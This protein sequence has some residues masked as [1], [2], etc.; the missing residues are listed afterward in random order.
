MSQAPGKEQAGRS[1]KSL[2][3]VG[4]VGE[5]LTRDAS[6]LGYDWADSVP[7]WITNLAVAPTG[8]ISI[9]EFDDDSF[10]GWTTVTVT[11]GQT[12][13][14]GSGLL[15]VEPTTLINAP[16][17]NCILQSHSIAIG[18]AVVV[19]IPAH[20]GPEVNFLFGPL[21]TDG[22]T[23]G[24]LMAWHAFQP[25][26]SGDAHFSYETG[27]AATL[28]ASS[29]STAIGRVILGAVTYLR[30]EYDAANTFKNWTSA[31]NLTWEE[32]HSWTTTIT[33]THVGFGWTTNGVSPT[34]MA[35]ALEY[36]RVVTV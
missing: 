11:G 2:D 18:D 27:S 34:N 7:Q 3:N 30:I 8:D 26:G 4:S 13:T 5:V 6:D 31:D 28:T 16:D 29:I 33:P 19:A 32:S 20:V 23:S 35:V 24:S 36:V 14:E 21:I 15:S 9:D 17:V 25:Y 22:T 1:L 12:I 10:T